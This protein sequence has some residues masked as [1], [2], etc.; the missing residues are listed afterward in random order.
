MRPFDVQCD[1]GNATQTSYEASTA[2]QAARKAEHLMKTMRVRWLVL[3]VC[4]LC[5][6]LRAMEPQGAKASEKFSEKRANE[7]LGEMA[8]GKFSVSASEYGEMVEVV[9]S[10]Q[11]SKS[12][13]N[14]LLMILYISLRYSEDRSRQVKALLPKLTSLIENEPDEETFGSY[15]GCI[16]FAF[17][18][19]DEGAALERAWF[20]KVRKQSL[21]KQRAFVLAL[22][23]PKW[24]A[25]QERFDRLLE[26]YRDE[27]TDHATRESII[28]TIF[29]GMASGGL[30]LRDGSHFYG[31]LANLPIHPPVL[32]QLMFQRLSEYGE[33]VLIYSEYSKYLESKD[34]EKN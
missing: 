14:N 31:N 17:E 1:V 7:L 4:L 18:D 21:G 20:A 22:G 19:G 10:E 32:T 29:A 9:S 15:L 33:L 28:D 26:I 13:R 34:T 3:V 12:H 24:S 23:L 8:S 27:A 11:T 25:P 30:S 5:S 16:A 2:L 6:P